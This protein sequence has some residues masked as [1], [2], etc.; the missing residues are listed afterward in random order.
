M[1]S[2][3]TRQTGTHWMYRNSIKITCRRIDKSMI[4]A[5]IRNKQTEKCKVGVRFK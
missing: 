1:K 3:T 2:G 4:I 5:L